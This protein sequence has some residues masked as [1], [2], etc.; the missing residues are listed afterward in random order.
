MIYTLQKRKSTY[1]ISQIKPEELSVFG[2]VCFKLRFNIYVN[3]YKAFFYFAVLCKR[4]QSPAKSTYKA[5]ISVTDN[6]YNMFLN[7]WVKLGISNT[8]TDKNKQDL[9]EDATQCA[10]KVIDKYVN[11]IING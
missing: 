4:S 6:K 1:S 5:F 2:S 10:T 3:E 11:D 7:P 8:W 9:I